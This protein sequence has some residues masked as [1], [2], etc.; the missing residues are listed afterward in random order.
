[1]KKFISLCLFLAANIINAQTCDVK[2]TSYNP[3]NHEVVVEFI[4][5]TNCGCNEFTQQ[6]NNTCGVSSST[7]VNNNESVSNLVFGL[8]YNDLYD[9]TSCTNTIYVPGWSFA[10]PVAGNWNNGDILTTQLDINENWECMLETPL[11]DYCWEI[12][13]WQINLS[14]TADVNDFPNEEWWSDTCGIC[15]NETH[16][17]PDINLSDNQLVFCP[18]D[19]LEI[20]G[21]TYPNAINYDSF[22]TVD[23]GSCEY[24]PCPIYGCTNPVA[25]NY[26]PTATVNDGNCIT[27]DSPYELG[28]EI[29]PNW[30]SYVLLFEDCGLIEECDTVY[31][32]LPPDTLTIIDVIDNFIYDTV[33]IELPSDTI[34]QTQIDTII[35]TEYVYATDTITEYITDTVFVDNPIIYGCTWP[36]SCNYNDEATVDDGSCLDCDTPYEV[37]QILCDAYI[38]IDGYWDWWIE[39]KGCDIEPPV[40]QCD[41]VYQYI[42]E[43]IIDTVYTEVVVDNYIYISDTLYLT[44]YIDCVSGEPCEDT[45]IDGI[46]GCDTTLYVPNTFTPN[47][48][49]LNDNFS[50]VTDPTC[51]DEWDLKI[52]NRWGNLVWESDS[53]LEYW[54]GDGA[55]TAVYVWILNASMSDFVIKRRGHI[56]LFR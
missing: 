56:T 37:G 53:P 6:D 45:T 43:I 23:N 20:Q 36:V 54:D 14:Q 8:H 27:C 11:D 17:Y 55:T 1:M 41:T 16:M 46:I 4:D 47:G 44:E 12:V 24:D 21:C 38:G 7:I 3:F 40:E 15:A 42:T 26:E 34:I 39:L 48:D 13:V 51:W 28:L 25:C 29:C 10:I 33:Y 19:E 9:N 50:I 31:L 30:E 49:G 52:Y 18:G 5:A 35:T 2:L 32:E 22:A